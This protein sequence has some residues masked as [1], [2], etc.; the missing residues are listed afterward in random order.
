MKIYSVY[1]LYAQMYTIQKR[2]CKC[3]VLLMIIMIIVIINVLKA[4]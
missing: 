3:I 2:K 1:L 4:E